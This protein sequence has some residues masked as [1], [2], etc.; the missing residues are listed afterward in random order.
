MEL[1]CPQPTT[2]PLCYLD[3]KRSLQCYQSL[4]LGRN[5]EAKLI[6]QCLS[7]F[8]SARKTSSLSEDRCGFVEVEG[9][10]VWTSAE[11]DERTHSGNSDFQSR[12]PGICHLRACNDLRYRGC[13]ILT[14]ILDNDRGQQI[15]TN[16]TQSKATVLGHSGR[17]C[18]SDGS[19]RK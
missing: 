13:V 16:A 3:M 19:G 8:R 6:M 15:P 12:H 4:R 14:V 10:N 9:Q 2:Q 17:R 11:L 5:S 7:L 1:P 18:F